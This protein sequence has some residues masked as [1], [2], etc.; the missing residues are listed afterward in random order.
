M[1]KR[2]LI[3]A[4]LLI[5]AFIVSFGDKTTASRRACPY[6]Q[7]CDPRIVNYPDG[8][9]QCGECSCQ[10]ITDG[11]IGKKKYVCGN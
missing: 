7:T 8:T 10:F 1:K 3:L 5:T 4:M 9:P 11:P 2:M 6:M